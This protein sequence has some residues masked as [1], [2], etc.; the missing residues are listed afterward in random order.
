MLASCILL[1]SIAFVYVQRLF[2]CQCIQVLIQ[3]AGF[4]A[5]LVAVVAAY[6]TGIE[7]KL[8]FDLIYVIL[9]GII[10]AL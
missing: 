5:G 10:C 3:L 1:H 8:D 2:S 4:V 9:F 7:L 6:V